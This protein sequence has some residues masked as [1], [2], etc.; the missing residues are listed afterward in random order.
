MTESSGSQ[1][2]DHRHSPRYA[3]TGE[4]EIFQE[5]KRV[6]WGKLTDIS[7]SGCYIET[8]RPLP[9]GA[10]TQLRLTVAGALLEFCATVAGSTPLVGM[11]MGFVALS[12]E[13]DAKLAQII[14]SIAASLSPAG[15]QA[16]PSPPHSATVQITREAAPAILAMIIKKINEK[17]IVT[18]QDLIDIVNVNK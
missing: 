15:Q 6:A 16:Q 18:R 12:P 13:Q 17:G 7:R 11:G 8:E 14:K 2:L 5:G 3:C 4:A 10:D 9:C 1:Q